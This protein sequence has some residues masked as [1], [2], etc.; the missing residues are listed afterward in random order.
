M[1]H[2]GLLTEREQG[3]ECPRKSV[4]LVDHPTR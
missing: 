2:L 1:N 4:D 3:T